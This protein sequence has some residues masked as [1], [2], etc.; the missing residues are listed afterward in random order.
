MVKAKENGPSRSCK[1]TLEFL[2][3]LEKLGA[4]ALMVKRKGKK[5]KKTLARIPRNILLRKT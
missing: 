1:D 4:A 3:D 5:K 2:V